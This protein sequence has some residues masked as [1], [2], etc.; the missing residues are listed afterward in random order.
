MDKLQLQ[1]YQVQQE[2]QA[3]EYSYHKMK[4]RF[5]Y[6]VTH[7]RAH[8]T[9]QGQRLIIAVID[10]VA[11]KITEFLKA[12]RRGNYKRAQDM[13]NRV[14]ADKPHDLAYILLMC[15]VRSVGKDTSVPM[16][17]LIRQINKTVYDAMLMADYL[18]DH[19]ELIAAIE[20]KQRGHRRDFLD[21][22]H[23]EKARI[24]AAS[25]NYPDL[26]EIGTMIGAILLDL[27]ILTNCDIIEQEMVRKKN[28][29]YAHIRFTKTCY[30]MILGAGE[31]LAEE[32][33]GYPIHVLPPRP[34][35]GFSGHGGYICEDLYHVDMIKA[36][37]SSRELLKGYLDQAGSAKL[38]EVLNTLGNTPWRIN[39]KIFELMDYIYENN[40]QDYNRPRNNPSLVGGLPYN[41]FL[42]PFDYVIRADYGEL[43]EENGRKDWMDK[44]NLD[45]FRDDLRRQIGICDTSNGNT[46]SLS[47]AL[48]EAKKYVS[49]ENIYF[50]Y[51]YDFRGRVYPIQNYLN[52][53][54]K[55]NIK[56]LLEFGNAYP[57]ATEEAQWWFLVHGANC[58][59][60][61]KLEYDERVEK[62]RA[63]HDDILKI[64]TS[65]LEHQALWKDCDEPFLFLA[66]AYEYAGWV[67]DPDNFL[68]RVPIA[69]DAVCSGIQIYSGLLKDRDGAEA[70]CVVGDKREDIYQKVAKVA[71]DVIVEGKYRKKI[72]MPAVEAKG[73]LP[74]REEMVFD[75]EAAANEFKGRMSRK[76][77]KRNTMTLPYSVTQ[78]GMYEQ[79]REI[80]NT[81]EADG[82]KFWTC[83]NWV[84][85]KVISEINEKAIHRVVKGAK[86]GQE[87]LKAI[88]KRVTSDG[89]YIFYTSMGTDFPVLQ[90]IHRTKTQ[91]IK[92]PVGRLSI[93]RS[94][95]AIDN[96][97][98]VN[99]IAPNFVHS[100]DAALLAMT[101]VRLR[102]LGCD[103]FHV[104]HDSYGVPAKFIPEL[105]QAVRESYVELFSLNPLE[106][107]VAQVCPDFE[108]PAEEVMINT[109]DL[110]EVLNSQYIFS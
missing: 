71:E 3:K 92:T 4:S 89:G 19:G 7:G 26:S 88:T 56:A 13:L 65:P 105:N 100:L 99:G 17:R 55:G 6:E 102:A 48:N 61:D 25:L 109:L 30:E 5:H 93:R 73:E 59:G 46:I 21:R 62:I 45:R 78:Y 42:D 83:E 36:Y 97:R 16:T 104:I 76:I 64:S 40:I 108:I 69:L 37:G 96:N 49:F 67:R 8:E 98:M 29:T 22:A 20:K 84:A 33:I 70:V 90:K 57:L 23:E 54:T 72:V 63:M 110:T 106:K 103:C 82:D 101:I 85:A 38:C 50:T 68:S 87:Y 81:M 80:F 27:L 66:W 9:Q 32:S 91:R 28:K 44:E 24:W 14:F 58:Y 11:D 79:L 12:D 31:S 60:Y 75:L 15:V 107:F 77:T 94:I 10:K 86:I 41:G 1:G 52:P 43:R 35:R 2:I 95:D 34:W 53:Q 47:L 51:Q 18:K 74:A 39:R